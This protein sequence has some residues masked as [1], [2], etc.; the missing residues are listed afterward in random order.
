MGI[1]IAVLETTEA[2]ALGMAMLAG[3]VG[4]G[5]ADVGGMAERAVRISDVFEPEP[6]RAKAYGRRFELYR[7]LYPAM[8]KVNH[9]L[10]R[11]ESDDS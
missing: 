7:Q 3:S 9:G 4:A 5:V 6:S 2:P 11:L 1:P 8:A 10:A